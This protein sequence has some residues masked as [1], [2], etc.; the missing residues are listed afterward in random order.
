MN[1]QTQCET[2]WNHMR[3]HGSIDPRIAS[4]RYDIDRLAARIGELRERVGK[5][6]IRTDM[7]RTRRGKRHANYVLTSGCR[8]N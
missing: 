7:V 8:G 5:K 6:K 4:R 1:R 2:V 3:E